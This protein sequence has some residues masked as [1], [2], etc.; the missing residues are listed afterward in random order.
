VTPRHFVD[1][2][3]KRRNRKSTFNKAVAGSSGEGGVGFLNI[4]CNHHSPSRH[5]PSLSLQAVPN[6]VPTLRAPPSSAILTMRSPTLVWAVLALCAAIA[7]AQTCTDGLRNGFETGKDCGGF[8]GGKACPGCAVGIGCL[9]ANDCLSKNCVSKVRAFVL[10]CCVMRLW[11]AGALGC[12]RAGVLNRLQ[13]G[14][15]KTAID[16]SCKMMSLLPTTARSRVCCR[17]VYAH[18]GMCRSAVCGARV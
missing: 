6:A 9:V 4:F 16:Q 10:P 11:V 14:G 3:Q 12:L 1:F 2:S 13:K 17:S 5:V 7:A 8:S 15:T 18:A